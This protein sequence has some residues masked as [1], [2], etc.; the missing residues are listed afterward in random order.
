MSFKDR[1]NKEGVP[2]HIA[3]IMDGNGRWAKEQGEMRIFGHRHGV[4]AVR[5]T[6]EGCIEVGIPYVTLYAFSTENWNR[7]QVE[8]QA[9]MEIMVDSLTKEIDTFQKNN[10]KLNAIGSLTDLPPHCLKKLTDTIAQTS[11]NTTCTLT[12]ALSYGSRKEITD[13]VRQIAEDVRRGN[14]KP[15]A[16]TEQ[17]ISE[18]LYT[19]HIPDPDLMIRTSGEQRVSN[20][21]LWQ[22]A[23]TEFVF[24]PIMWPDFTREHLFECVYNYQHRERRFGKTSEQL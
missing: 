16:I 12:L 11:K 19:K 15:E 22:I 8:V 10:V 24:L 9:L 18:H 20:Y 13:A 17:T 14:I 5:E 1:L 7:P 6:L 23:Y 3:I 21:M 4:N 2:T